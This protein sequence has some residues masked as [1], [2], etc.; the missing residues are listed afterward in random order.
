MSTDVKTQPAL[1]IAQMDDL[2]RESRTLVGS[3]T[4][5]SNELDRTP[6]KLLFGDRHKGYA[7]K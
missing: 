7:P 5:L 6:T 1:R 2:L 4:R 3:L